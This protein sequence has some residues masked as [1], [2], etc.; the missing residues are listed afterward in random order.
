MSKEE[1]IQVALRVVQDCITGSTPN[2]RDVEHLRVHGGA[3]AAG[4]EPD[5]LAAYIVRRE[6]A[7]MI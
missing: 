6:I 4:L 1:L 3:A 2:S 5:A 7:D